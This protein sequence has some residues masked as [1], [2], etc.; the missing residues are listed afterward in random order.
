MSTS[1]SVT[2]AW[3]CARLAETLAARLAAAAAERPKA[4]RDI[5]VSVARMVPSN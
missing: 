5:G 3:A 1:F 2:V 4:R